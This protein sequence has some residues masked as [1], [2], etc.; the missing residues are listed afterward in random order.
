MPELQ[1]PAAIDSYNAFNAHARID[2]SRPSSPTGAPVFFQAN[3]SNG[4]CGNG[5]CGHIAIATGQTT[6]TGEPLLRSTGW[7][8]HTCIFAATLSE[9]EAVGSAGYLGCAVL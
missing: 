4:G 6:W 3:G 1:K 8:E 2:T 9:L 7:A 5:G